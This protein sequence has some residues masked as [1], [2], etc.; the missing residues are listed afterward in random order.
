MELMELMGLQELQA[1][2]DH[3]DLVEHQVQADL[4]DLVELQVHPDHQD[5]VVHPE[6]VV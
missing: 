6:Q 5:L 4:L 2:A 1:Q 3:Q